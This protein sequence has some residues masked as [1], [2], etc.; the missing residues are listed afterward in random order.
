[1]KKGEGGK[2]LGCAQFKWPSALILAEATSA[3]SR[4]PSA[5]ASEHKLKIDQLSIAQLIVPLA[6]TVFWNSS[7]AL[8]KTSENC[9]LPFTLT[10]SCQEGT[11]QRHAFFFFFKINR[12]GRQCGIREGPQVQPPPTCQLLIWGTLSP[13]TAPLVGCNSDSPYSADQDSAEDVP[14]PQQTERNGSCCSQ[15]ERWVQWMEISRDN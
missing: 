4:S 2:G 8:G 1:M 6:N 15:G 3:Q 10:A 5:A 7:S 9:L 14:A 12:L 11:P 13:S